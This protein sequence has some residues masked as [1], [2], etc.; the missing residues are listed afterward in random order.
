MDRTRILKGALELK[1]NERNLCDSPEHDDLVTY[2]KTR[3][4][5]EKVW[6]ER[7]EKRCF[8]Y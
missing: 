7:R 1:S 5:K 6:E 2:W 8:I 4:G 3:R